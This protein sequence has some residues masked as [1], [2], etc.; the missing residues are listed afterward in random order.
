MSKGWV[1]KIGNINIQIGMYE[2]DYFCIG[3]ILRIIPKSKHFI[4]AH[5]KL[6]WYEFDFYVSKTINGAVG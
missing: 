5:L 6:I 4:Q 3:F 1:N 2:L